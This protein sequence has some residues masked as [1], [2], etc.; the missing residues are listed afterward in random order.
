MSTA[1][2]T[3]R[4]L[5]STA[6][7][8]IVVIGSLT[9]VSALALLVL[10]G[11]TGTLS[12]P[13]VPVATS[14]SALV[15]DVAH[16]RGTADVSRVIGP[17][18]VHVAASADGSPIFV[19]IGR[20][21]D[22]DRYLAGVATDEVSAFA[23]RSGPVGLARHPGSAAATPPGQ[24]GFWVASAT[25]PSFADVSWRVQDGDYRVVVMHVDG[26]PGVTTQVRAE[27]N[28]PNM[29]GLSLAVLAGGLLATT[30]GIALIVAANRRRRATA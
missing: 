21:A 24:Q 5:G 18:T 29:F 13:A 4:L 12:T 9:A 26:T 23:D 1:H 11:S 3:R 14:T 2:T 30:G 22:V 20:A 27:I 15:A 6:G 8:I 16:S 10:F 7:A 17:P 25:S 28:T 19:G